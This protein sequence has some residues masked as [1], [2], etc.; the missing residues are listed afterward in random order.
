[1]KF[2]LIFS[3]VIAA[4][5]V[6]PAA[7]VNAGELTVTVS[8]IRAAK[9]SLLVSVVNT[10]AA[11]NGEEKPLAADKV[12][13]A[14]K[15]KPGEPVV[16]KF[17]LPAGSYAVQVMHDENDN[18]KLDSNFMGIPIEG[19]GFSNNPQVMRRAYFSEA[20]F[21]ITG[22]PTAIVVRLR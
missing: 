5:F 22:A 10:E 1:M 11:W 9:G 13:V 3:S 16:F 15:V 12:V 17:N 19:Y 8:D 18:G 14:D 20:K 4:G 21:D 2:Q 6:L 7:F